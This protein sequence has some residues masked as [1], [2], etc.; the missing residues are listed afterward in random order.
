MADSPRS[1]D[2]RPPAGAEVPPE[3]EQIVTAIRDGEVDAFVIHHEGVPEIYTLVSAR[4]ALREARDR[5]QIA[6]DAAAM[7]TWDYDLQADT[8]H[9]DLRHDY[10]FGYGEVQSEWN[11]DIARR[12]IVPQDQA[13]FDAARARALDDGVYQFEGRVR[14]ADG[15]LHWLHSMGRT[16][17]DEAGRPARIAGVVMDVTERREAVEALREL[18]DTL[19]QQVATRTQELEIVRDQFQTA[20]HANPA[21]TAIMHRR[22]GHLLD[23]NAEYSRFFGFAREDLVGNTMNALGLWADPAESRSVIQRVRRRKSVR[24]QEVRARGHTGDIRTVLVS[25]EPIDLAGEPCALV[26]FM[27]I[28]ARK[29]AE[30]ALRHLSSA[31]TLAEQRERRRLS[32]VLHDDLQQ[33]LFG[34]EM[35]TAILQNSLTNRDRPADPA[36][37]CE[38]IETLRTLLAG[39][40]QTTR[41]LSLELN[42]PVLRGEGLGAA[43]VWLARHMEEMHGLT[44]EV[45][46]PADDYPL[47]EDQRVLLVQLV[48]E[49]LFNVVK[50]AG[51][52]QARLSVSWRDDRLVLQVEDGGAGFDAQ[53]RMQERARRDSLGLFS[54]EERLRLFGGSLD[55]DSRPGGGTRARIEIPLG[56]NVRPDLAP[57]LGPQ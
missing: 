21:A 18:N 44:I 14:W 17:F 40:V 26:M 46:I 30:E 49:L 35:R 28:T 7:G 50:H 16:H 39:A 4:E 10:L 52:P 47:L 54:V 33:I 57:I 13:A 32:Q 31:L 1:E 37:I 19:E 55:V 23:V 43:L 3:P 9:R 48:R 27:D 11:T 25:A 22:E 56:H 12:H 42:P 34:V 41:A 20:F 29:Q 45:D 38:Q 2:R 5:L 6:L 8:C 51:V 15:S 53:E 36:V 24:N